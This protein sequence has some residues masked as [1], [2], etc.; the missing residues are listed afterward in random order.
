LPGEYRSYDKDG[1]GQVGLYEWP[2]DRIR[3][4]IALDR[5]DD[6]FLTINELR[7]P[8]SSN[9]EKDRT[10]EKEKEPESKPTEPAG[11]NL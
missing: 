4:F 2:K 3:D 7:K 10:K 6:G 1:D 11:D 9:G 8:S 5:N